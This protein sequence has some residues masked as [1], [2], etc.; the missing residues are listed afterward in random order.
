MSQPRGPPEPQFP[1]LPAAQ[2][3]VRHPFGPNCCPLVLP[4]PGSSILVREGSEVPGQVLSCVSW[5]PRAQGLPLT[6]HS[7]LCSDRAAGGPE[8]PATPSSE[9]RRQDPWRGPWRPGPSSP[10]SAGE[11]TGASPLPTLPWGHACKRPGHLCPQGAEKQGCLGRKTVGAGCP[12]VPSAP[13]ASL[14][15]QSRR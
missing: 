8:K 4:V 6:V 15:M 13:A 10:D 1:P 14:Q 2:L 12:P 5:E 7:M 11:K 3:M 9:L